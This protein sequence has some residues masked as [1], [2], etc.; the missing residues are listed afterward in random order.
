M[1]NPCAFG[2]RWKF[3]GRDEIG[4]GRSGTCPFLLD[5]PQNGAEGT[6]FVVDARHSVL[7]FA[8]DQREGKC[9]KMIME[10]IFMMAF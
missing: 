9:T 8:I 4:V 2:H 1:E 5:W 7:P 10:I 3:V 6:R